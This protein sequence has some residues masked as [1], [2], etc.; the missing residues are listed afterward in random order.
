MDRN[1]LFLQQQAMARQAQQQRAAAAAQAAAQAGGIGPGGTGPGGIGLGGMAPPTP[2]QQAWMQQQAQQQVQQQQRMRQQQQQQQQIPMNLIAQQQQ[3]QLENENRLK[4]Q[5]LQQQRLASMYMQQR[6]AQVQ[7]QQQ[8][9]QA[10]IQQRMQLQQQ[11]QQQ[12]LMLQQQQAAAAQQ[13]VAQQQQRPVQPM[14][15]IPPAPANATLVQTPL[16]QKNLELY[17]GRDQKYQITLDTQHKRHMELATMKKHDIDIANN[18]RKIRSQTRG[19]VT[20]GK[21]YDGYGNG[22]NGS[23]N[24]VIYPTDNKKRKRHHN[25]LKLSLETSNEQATKEEMLVPIRLDVENDGYKIR[26]TFTWNMNGKKAIY[27]QKFSRGARTILMSAFRLT[28]MTITPDQFAEITCEDLRLPAAVFVP[29]IATSIKDQIQ[30]YFLNA[31]SMIN[32]NQGST[33]TEK[34]A[35]EEFIQCKKQKMDLHED[36]IMQE[37]ETEKSSETIMT[38]PKHGSRGEL[39]TIIKVRAISFDWDYLDVWANL[40]LFSLISSLEIEY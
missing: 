17:M 20:F 24:R 29:L 2:D 25:T 40:N 16:Q 30:D 4:Q 23:S 10:Q 18:E 15:V 6:D 37:K 31:S 19:I 27:C 21:G 5:K 8:A 34:N 13:A 28:E 26:D 22:K 32:D 11:Q 39:R 33:T 14:Q 9:Q 3:Q 7:V 36:S 1:Y 38:V 12:Q 35:Y